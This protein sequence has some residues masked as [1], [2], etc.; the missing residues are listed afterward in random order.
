MSSAYAHKVKPKAHRAPVPSEILDRVVD[1]RPLTSE[2]LEAA[3]RRLK[4]AIVELA[5]GAELSHHVGYALGAGRPEDTT[6]HRNG[7]SG[8]PS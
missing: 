2:E 8:R 7:T 3:V 6:D 4:K 5:L 1:P